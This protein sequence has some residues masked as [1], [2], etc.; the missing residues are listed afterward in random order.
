[1]ILMVVISDSGFSSNIYVLFYF[2]HIL[3]KNTM[4]IY[5]EINKN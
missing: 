2:F 1:M 5:F 3:Y 4:D